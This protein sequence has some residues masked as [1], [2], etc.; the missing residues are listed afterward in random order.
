LDEYYDEYYASETPLTGADSEEEKVEDV[1]V[2]KEGVSFV[3]G[4]FCF[5][6]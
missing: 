2:E 3:D 6:F 1:A 5:G 4:E